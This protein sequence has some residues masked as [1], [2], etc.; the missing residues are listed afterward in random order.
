MVSNA[1]Q[2]ESTGLDKKCDPQTLLDMTHKPLAI[3]TNLVAYTDLDSFWKGQGCI[4]A[5]SRRAV[6][7][8][9]H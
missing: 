8:L 7:S 2:P 9:I 4:S 1:N 5:R 6:L 3:V